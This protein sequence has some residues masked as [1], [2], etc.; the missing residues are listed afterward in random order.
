MESFGANF[1]HTTN[2]GGSN[3]LEISFD[4]PAITN[5]N[6]FDGELFLDLLGSFVSLPTTIIKE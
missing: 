6:G 3:I 2:G 4:P 5:F 1:K